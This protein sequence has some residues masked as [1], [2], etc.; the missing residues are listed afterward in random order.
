MSTPDRTVPNRSS[1][2][3]P[4]GEILAPSPLLTLIAFLI[5]LAIDW[6]VPVALLPWPWNLPLGAVLLVLGSLVFG[7]AI[8][9][10]RARGKHPSHSDE[11]PE[12]IREGVYQYSRNPIYV[13]HSIAHVGGGLLVNSVWPLVTLVPVLLY[14][15]RV[16]RQE[17]ARLEA[18][19]GEEY[20]QY[21]ANVRRWL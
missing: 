20:D 7:G 1:D 5:G 19:F 14:L 13:G 17:E 12:L 2:E 16:I 15:R 18:L 9:T 11:P 21:R 6:A 10:M 8:R 4:P 3:V